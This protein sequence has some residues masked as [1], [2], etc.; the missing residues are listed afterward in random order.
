MPTV[1]IGSWTGVAVNPVPKIVGANPGAVST[2]DSLPGE[3]K[4]Y[5]RSS[6]P[7]DE[8]R[9]ISTV[10]APTISVRI[11]FLGLRVVLEV[12]G[13]LSSQ[14]GII[15]EEVELGNVSEKFALFNDRR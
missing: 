8:H 13:F 1:F 7:C 2:V 9:Q 10:P 6:A 3:P 5:L 14:E 15:V 11:G 4:V 12:L